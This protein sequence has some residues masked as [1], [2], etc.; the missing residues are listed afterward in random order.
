MTVCALNGVFKHCTSDISSVEHIIPNAIGGR[1]KTS[2]CICAKCN[3]DS[4]HLWD[5][6]LCKQFESL[7]LLFGI[8]RE[9]GDVQPLQVV[10]KTTKEQS[11]LSSDGKH[12]PRKPIIN[13]PDRINEAFQVSV[14]SNNP[15]QGMKIL[16]SVINKKCLTVDWNTLESRDTF[17]DSAGLNTTFSYDLAGPEVGRAIAK[18]IYLYAIDNGLK[19]DDLNVAFNYLSSKTPIQCF[20]PYYEVDLISDRPEPIPLHALA[21]ES[22]S[23]SRLIVGYVEIFGLF[24]YSFKLGDNYQ[25]SAIKESYVFDPVAG[26]EIDSEVNTRILIDNI[27]N[28]LNPTEHSCNALNV[29]LSQKFPIYSQNWFFKNQQH[30]SSVVLSEIYNRIGDITRT[31]YDEAMNIIDELLGS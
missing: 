24:R 14:N 28:Y 29:L 7:S 6:V 9:R 16:K 15:E 31:N 21:I 13:I 11:I 22:V 3:N 25:G 10:D 12:Q 18:M 19:K 26:K 5:S 17:L 27:D 20:G 2:K 23:H 8:T 4:G 30:I 1:K